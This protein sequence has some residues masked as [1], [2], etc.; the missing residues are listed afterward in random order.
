M[1]NTV[2]FYY[3]PM[4]RGQIVHWMLEECGAPYEIKLIDWKTNQQKSAEF[5]KINP[6]GKLPAIVHKN[7]VVTEGL[8][9]CAY[10]ADAFPE[11]KLAPP[12]TDPSRGS[13]Y[14]WMFFTVN[15][16]DPA[17]ADK[18]AP[19]E[20]AIP[21]MALG[22]GSFEDVMRTLEGAVKDGF[23]VNNTFSAA[24]L[25]LSAVLGWYFSVKMLEP[26]PVLDAYV[27]RCTERPKYKSFQQK[28][29]TM[30]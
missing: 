1:N 8:A 22:Y 20:K 12:F 24:D 28:L 19:R 4:S 16:L 14:R 25:Y 6:M 30:L 17:V 29:S 7:T 3:N 26:T 9:I 21:S 18:N 27:K 2:D 10:L 23:L 11:S 13:Y 15:C 5:L